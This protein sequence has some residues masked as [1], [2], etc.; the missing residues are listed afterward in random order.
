M[1]AAQ[2]SCVC[3]QNGE[4]LTPGNLEQSLHQIKHEVSQTGFASEV[5]RDRFVWANRKS[6]SYT[7]KGN[8]HNPP[9]RPVGEYQVPLTASYMCCFRACLCAASTTAVLRLCSFRYCCAASAAFGVLFNKLD[10]LM[11]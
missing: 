2:Q 7:S 5:A 9:K 11:S 1:L 4:A 8:K 10:E 6:A 3:R